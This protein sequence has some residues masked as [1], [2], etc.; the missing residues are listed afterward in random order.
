M[1][2]GH[3]AAQ[4]FILGFL[5]EH[6][7]EL[8]SAR[9]IAELRWGRDPTRVEVQ[10]IRNAI[11]RLGGT[12]G[13]E[14]REIEAYWGIIGQLQDADG[15]WRPKRVFPTLVIGRDVPESEPRRPA[16]DVAVDDDPGF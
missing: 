12:P 8:W 13:V 9:Q 1:S 14:V 11:R 15:L 3:G 2:R 16:A 6:P 7:G 10:A 4:R 5:D